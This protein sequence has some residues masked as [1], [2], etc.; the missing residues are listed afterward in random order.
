MRRV[1]SIVDLAYGDSGK[2]TMV[3][4]YAK[5]TDAHTVVRSSGGAQAAHNVVADDGRHH[6]FNQFGAASFRPGVRT[7][8]S[9]YMLVNPMMLCRENDRL[10]SV[11]VTDALARL[12]IDG[13]APM[14]TPFHRAA[15]WLREIARGSGEHG[16]CGM[17]IGETAQDVLA[18]G[19]EMIYANDLLDPLR[20]AR[21]A[22]RLRTYKRE[23]LA[24]LV[25]MLPTPWSDTT[26]QA[27]E[28]LHG[29][30]GLIRFLDECRWLCQRITIEDG[31]LH[32]LLALEGT[33]LFE[34]AQGV[35]LDEW[36]GFHPHTTWTTTT[37][38]NV[39]LLLAEHDYRGN[40]EKIGVVRTY[41]TRHGAGPLVTEDQALTQ[42]LR[43]PHN[44][45]DG[46][47]KHFRVGWF[48][49]V[50]IKY[51]LEV[52]GKIDGLAVTHLDRTA[53]L[54]SLP[55]CIAYRA[56]DMPLDELERYVRM[57][58]GAGGKQIARLRVQRGRDL[59]WQEGLTNV[60]KAC[61]PIYQP[62][63]QEDYLPF[64]AE[65]L[66][67]PIAATSS[68]LTAQDKRFFGAK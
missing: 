31:Y 22:R 42:R 26:R 18:L 44:G 56:P 3:D 33:V 46:W 5:Q 17:G 65:A 13:R 34:G 35:L 28:V 67:T 10:K 41:A 53:D 57:G 8:L 25:S 6:T 52:V 29:E 1:I 15:N 7:H 27:I 32:N 14:T 24:E 12:S 11:G 37:F 63:R 23:Q 20:L 16:T 40:V 48:D 68:G 19:A 50:A 2:G 66:G 21:K 64:L 62:V 4:A 38:E 61:T 58:H 49:L 60:V 54:S 59:V 47:Q 51:A 39:D 36:Y 55:I 45:D 43:D 30:D 9:R